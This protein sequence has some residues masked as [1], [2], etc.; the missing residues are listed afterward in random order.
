MATIP[1]RVLL[2]LIDGEP[3]SAEA[4]AWLY[5]AEGRVSAERAALLDA[6]AE[7]FEYRAGALARAMPG[8][9]DEDARLLR[10]ALRRHARRAERL[11]GW[12]R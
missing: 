5:G 4:D 11:R 8:L 9:P 12:L 2:N 7:R 10:D 6:E 3:L 1:G